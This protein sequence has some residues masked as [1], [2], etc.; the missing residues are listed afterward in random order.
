[1]DDEVY[2]KVIEVM[3]LFEEKKLKNQGKEIGRRWKKHQKKEIECKASTFKELR[4][5]S[6]KDCNSILDR[7]IEK[8]I[9]LHE[10]TREAKHMKEMR[11]VQLTLMDCMA[12][13]HW[14]TV[15]EKLV[16]NLFVYF[17]VNKRPSSFH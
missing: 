17:T 11:E 6:V 16:L 7:I 4:S 2:N 15:E 12:E 5:L 9:T 1:M 3:E 13:T 10:L 8:E 14:N